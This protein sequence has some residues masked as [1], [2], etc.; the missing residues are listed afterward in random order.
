MIRMRE[1]VGSKSD[2]A[3]IEMLVHGLA[4]RRYYA[5]MPRTSTWRDLR[6]QIKLNFGLPKRVQ[7]FLIDNKHVLPQEKQWKHWAVIKSK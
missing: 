7:I 2:G 3:D 1:R 6:K 4:G 5:V